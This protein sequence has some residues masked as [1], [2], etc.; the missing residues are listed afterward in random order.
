MYSA[1]QRQA[2]RNA[3]TI[4]VPGHT[5]L[6]PGEDLIRIGEWC[7][8]NSVDADAYGSGQLIQSFEAKVAAL[9]GTEAAVFMPSGTM[10]QQIAARIHCERAVGY[11][12]SERLGMHPTCHLEVH[13]QRGYAFLHQLKPVLVGD[14]T[15]PIVAKD[16]ESLVEIPGCLIVELPAREIGGQ[17]PNWDELQSLKQAAR[18]RGIAL[19]LDG[20]R[21]WEAATGYAGHSHADICKGFDSV[22]VSFYKGIGAPAGAMLLG[23]KS[24]IAEARIW[25]R[26]HGGNL[27]QQLPFVAGAA[28]RF[29]ERLARMPAYFERAK[30]LA[31][32]LSA[33]DG[34][35]INPAVPQANMFH[36]HLP[37]SHQAVEEARDRIAESEKCWLGAPRGA[38]DVPGWCA[39]EL[40]VGENLMTLDD[41]FVVGAYR[42]LL[43][44]AR[45][46]DAGSR[47]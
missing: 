7:K 19:Q 22:Y 29:D 26:R 47:R 8:A 24:F 37:A 44:G 31:R 16:I 39:M 42:R 9:L 30:A 18:A 14:R 5:R 23:D 17:M 25:Q 21:L 38:S 32:A 41:D 15:R 11:G 36:L 4:T 35:V 46:I 12:K 33:I 13:E 10:A 28:M 45:K 6:P 2:L 34:V 40:Y 43:G 3:C 27:V 20:A 1:E